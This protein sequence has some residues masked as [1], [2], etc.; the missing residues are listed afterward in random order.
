MGMKV[1]L[2]CIPPIVFVLTIAVEALAIRPFVTDD[3][4]VVGSKLAQLETWLVFDRRVIEHNALF[5]LGPT[6]WLELTLGF[7]HGGV[8]SGADRGYSITGPIVQVK[9]LAAPARDNG[10]P[11]LALSLG[12]LSPLGS[13]S[14]TPPGGSG[15]LFVALTESLLD[16]WLLLHLNV[17][18]ALGDRNRSVGRGIAATVT[19]GFGFQARIYAGM[20]AVAEVYY[21]DPYDPW[22]VFPAAQVG[23]RYVFNDNVQIDGTFG[24]SLIAVHGE[25]GHAR[26]ERWGT[27]GLRLV[28]PELW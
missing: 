5:A 21:G 11:G 2:A 6:D 17:G 4:R 26:A 22:L 3:A 8:H 15:F 19:A 25:S 16:E 7:L 9:A 12:V 1:A 13:G 28:T 20:H 23:F 24:S 14:F 27:L 18:V 10:W